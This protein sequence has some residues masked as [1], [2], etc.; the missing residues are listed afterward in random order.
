MR[1]S[2]F[3]VLGFWVWSL[4]LKGVA[5]GLRVLGFWDLGVKFRVGMFGLGLRLVV[6]VGVW[7]RQPLPRTS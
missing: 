7:A 1:C 4:R 2:E 5:V 6:R 3:K